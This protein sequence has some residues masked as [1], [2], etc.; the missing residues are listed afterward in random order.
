MVPNH[1]KV[2]F[3]QR[4]HGLISEEINY[5]VSGGV[6]NLPTVCSLPHTTTRS[7]VFMRIVHACKTITS[8][9]VALKLETASTKLYLTIQLA[10]WMVF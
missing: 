3:G 1:Y 5:R 10:S 2:G 6:L 8:S 7:S 4:S 9:E